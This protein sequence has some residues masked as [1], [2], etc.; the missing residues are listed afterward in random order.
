[1]GFS[2]PLVGMIYDRTGSYGPALYGM[3]VGSVLSSLLYLFIGRYRYTFDFKLMV[4][5]AKVERFVNA[6]EVLRG[7]RGP[8]SQAELTDPDPTGG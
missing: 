3:I 7:W 1:M 6:R 2:A 5:P 4:E 8:F